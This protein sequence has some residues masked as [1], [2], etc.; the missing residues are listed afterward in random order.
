MSTAVVLAPSIL[1]VDASAVSRTHV[2]GLIRNRWPDARLTEAADSE[3][4][5]DEMADGV[6]DLVLID[7]P[8]AAGL[9]LAQHLRQAHPACQVALVREPGGLA[10]CDDGDGQADAAGIRLFGKPLTG[11]VVEQIL[12]LVG[13]EN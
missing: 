1:V 6:P 7:L 2:A 3:A 13:W 4:T 8:D 9:S 5:W 11:E 10:P 12:A